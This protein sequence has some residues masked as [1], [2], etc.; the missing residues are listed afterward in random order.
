MREKCGE[1]TVRERGGNGEE[2]SDDPGEQQAAR[3]AGLL[4][5]IGGHDKDTGADHGPDHDHG[6][7]EKPD[8]A[9]EAAFGRGDS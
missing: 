9:N 8:G 7:V 2:S 4:G 6:A 3:G 1:L 5:N